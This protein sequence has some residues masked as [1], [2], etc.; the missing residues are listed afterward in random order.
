MTHAPLLGVKHSVST[1]GF[2]MQQISRWGMEGAQ[3]RAADKV[4]GETLLTK[5]KCLAADHSLLNSYDSPI[6]GL[7]A[8]CCRKHCQNPEVNDVWPRILHPNYQPGRR[9][10]TLNH[11]RSP[12]HHL[13]LQEGACKMEVLHTEIKGPSM[14]AYGMGPRKQGF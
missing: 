7:K 5:S 4:N 13:P 10:K 12:K 9:V 2:E 11:T 1:T 8:R 6:S 3:W 14:R